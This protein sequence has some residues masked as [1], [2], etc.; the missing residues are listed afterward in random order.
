MVQ[1]NMSENLAS[2]KKSRQLQTV[3]L[4]FQLLPIENKILLE[5]LF[6]LLHRVADHE[7]TKMTAET[8][9]TLFAPCILA[10]RKV[11]YSHYEIVL[12]WTWIWYYACL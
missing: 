8:L 6:M 7:E 1:Q 12:F 10:P 2:M 9:G 11:F 5:K 3:Q 4:L